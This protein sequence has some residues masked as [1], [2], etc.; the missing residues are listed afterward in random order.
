MRIKR[1]S[2]LIRHAMYPIL[3]TVNFNIEASALS[4]NNCFNNMIIKFFIFY[5]CIINDYYYNLF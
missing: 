1:N 3:E 2:G 5:L 4:L